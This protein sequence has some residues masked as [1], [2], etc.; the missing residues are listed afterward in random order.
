MNDQRRKSIIIAIIGF[1][2]VFL[3]GYLLGGGNV[4]DVRWGDDTAQV[5]L[6]RAEEYQ[7]Q[8]EQGISVAAGTAS[9]VADAIGSGRRAVTDAQDAAEGIA[10][11][12]GSSRRAV[13]EAADAA[14]RLD[15][16]FAR[17]G[18][19]LTECEQIIGSIQKRGAGPVAQE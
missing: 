6:G 11:T 10:G 18:A 3:A 5:E 13:G 19:I 7:R 14:A 9:E 8:A 2:I 4:S 15:N 12:V 17:A 1:F 16:G